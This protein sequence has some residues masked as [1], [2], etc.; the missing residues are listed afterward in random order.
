M[1]IRSA[2]PEN[3]CLIFFVDGKKQKKT[4]KNICET[5]TLPP[6]RRL[7]KSDK[8]SDADTHYYN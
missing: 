8:L 6:H 2:V 1:K 3:G 5:Y 7:R 4:E